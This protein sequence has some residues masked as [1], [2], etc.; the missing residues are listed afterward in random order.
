MK[1]II[2]K[3]FTICITIFIIVNATDLFSQSYSLDQPVEVPIFQGDAPSGIS[4]KHYVWDITEI[5]ST[6]L[7]LV[8]GVNQI[9]YATQ[10]N[11]ING[12]WYK[13]QY[14]DNFNSE[15]T[16]TRY[17][18][19]FGE[20]IDP[21]DS[22]NFIRTITGQVLAEINSS[23]GKKDIVVSRG[24][25]LFTYEN[26][27]SS[28][29][30]SYKQRFYFKAGTILSSGNFTT[31]AVEDV[32]VHR[33]DSI[34]V[35]KGLGTDSKLDSIPAF[36]MSGAS[37]SNL[38]FEIAQI[39]SWIEPYATVNATTSNR[40]EIVMRQ[41]DSIIIFIN[42]NNNGI[43]SSYAI[44]NLTSV[45]EFA[46]G[47]VNNDGFND[48]LTCSITQGIKIFLNNGTSIDTVADYINSEQSQ[49]QSIYYADFDKDGWNDIIVNTFDSLKIF[50]NN[51]SSSMFSQSR[52]YS[53]P[54]SD[55]FLIDLRDT[56]LL[57][58][59]L[60]NKGGL[61]VLQSGFP[62]INFESAPYTEEIMYRYNP[63]SIDAVPAP[64]L[65][66]KD[67]VLVGQHYR[68]RLY[69]FNRGDRDFQKYIIYKKSP[70]F[71]NNNWYL[72]DSSNTSGEYIDYDEGLNTGGGEPSSTN[73]FYYA[74][75]QDNSYQVSI[76]SDTIDYLSIVCPGC[77]YEVEGRTPVTNISD[78][79]IPK[80]YKITNYPNPFNPVTK[81][82][83]D[84]PNEGNVRITIF[85]TAGQKITELINEYK[86]AGSY[87]VDFNGSN[88]ASGIYYYRLE[89][90][91]FSQVR[92]MILLK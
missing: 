79:E 59:D 9:K 78:S 49:T 50:L 62:A 66:F 7:D 40:D 28:I 20:L 11:Y 85:N 44:N 68:P 47:D 61:S 75:A 58:A 74:K 69:L 15:N 37:G 63:V 39:S 60:Q 89:S 32:L 24:D 90:G 70:N 71:N 38:K 4:Y 48:L 55:G 35:F 83:F 1:N 91:N 72:L 76:N 64:P 31:D 57:V 22:L 43:S 52:T 16:N 46:I 12:N 80:N 53:I 26:V 67:Q 25:S 8:A 33:N 45:T 3:Y 92:K 84:I 65:L 27:S 19:Q 88:L 30:T 54:V 23:S 82:I 34:F 2:K 41:G 77:G 10:Y 18:Y 73:C 42:D 87:Q 81:I 51:H 6:R 5:S 17:I 36:K 86:T 29:S 13:N 21:L 56:K 14:D